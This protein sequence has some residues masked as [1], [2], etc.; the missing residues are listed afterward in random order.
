MKILGVVTARG[1]SKT[2]PGKN[3]KPLGGKPLIA[4]SIEAA[5]QSGVFDRTI[6]STDDQAIAEAAEALGCERPFLRPASL[7]RDD[8]PHLPVVQHAVDTLRH[9]GYDAD[10]VMILQPTSPLR[11]PEDIRCAVDLL[12]ATGA[13]SVIS[14]SKVPDHYNPLRTVRVDDR[15]LATM[16]VDGAPVRTRPVR[17]QDVP[18]AWAIDGA[19][20]LFRTAVLSAAPPSLY[21]DSTA[22]YVTPPPYGINI[23]DLDDWQQAERALAA[24]GSN[25]G[26]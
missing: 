10:A 17:R 18:P 2:I 26:H 3:L 12:E 22:V 1:G 25:H 6:I 24:L 21:G 4:Y 19:I 9:G 23:D 5:R 8:T 7:A 15:G 13:D 11:R 16:F 20:Y 14:V